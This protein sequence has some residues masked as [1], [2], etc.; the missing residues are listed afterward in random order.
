MENHLYVVMLDDYQ[1]PSDTQYN[2]SL[3]AENR[4]KLNAKLE[5]SNVTDGQTESVPKGDWNASW[6]EPTTMH[7]RFQDKELSG[8]KYLLVTR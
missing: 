8:A 2:V 4:A 1:H 6:L 5:N 7:H 3:S